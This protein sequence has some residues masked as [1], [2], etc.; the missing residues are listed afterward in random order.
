MEQE[1]PDVV[2]KE[3]YQAYDFLDMKL[4]SVRSS[5]LLEDGKMKSFAGQFDSHLFISSS[6]LKKIL[7][8]VGLLIIMIMLWN[9]QNRFLLFREWQLL[10]R[11]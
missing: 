3:I 5:A 2:W 7:R 8:N 6:D 10:S 9:M 11:R 1:I 4:V